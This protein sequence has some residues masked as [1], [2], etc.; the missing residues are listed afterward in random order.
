M[1]S[2]KTRK[3]E[4]LIVIHLDGV[5]KNCKIHNAENLNTNILLQTEEHGRNG[6]Y[7]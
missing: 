1:N 5:A 3:T 4:R 2:K 7:I 6:M